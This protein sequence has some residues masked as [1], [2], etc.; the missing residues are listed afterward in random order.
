MGHF[1]TN[2]LKNVSAKMSLSV[3]A[4]NLKRAIGIVGVAHTL[5]VE[6]QVDTG[7][8]QRLKAV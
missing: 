6:V 5:L 3:L 7:P 1:R 8:A 4:Y 2:G